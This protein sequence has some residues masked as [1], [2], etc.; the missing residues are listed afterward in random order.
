MRVRRFELR[1]LAAIL[2]GLW[3]ATCVLLLGWYR[4]GGP[5]DLAVGAAALVPAC[6]AATAVAWPPEPGSRRTFVAVAWLGLLTVLVL[7]PLTAAVATQA[8]GTRPQAIV[9]SPEVAY[10]WLLALAGTSLFAATGIVRRVPGSMAS[11][12]DRRRRLAAAGLLATVLTVTSAGA[13]GGAALANGA[14][15]RDRPATYSRFGPTGQGLVPPACD[16]GIRVGPTATL[17]AR[18]EGQADRET[19]GGATL[20]GARSGDDI[21]WTADVATAAETGPAGVVTVGSGGWRREPG[22]SWETVPASS[23]AAEH[24][25][26]TVLAAA[27]PAERRMAVEDR[28]LVYVE[29]ARARHCRIAIDGETFRAAFPQVRWFAGDR[30][31]HRWRGELDFYVFGDGQLGLVEAWVNG[32]AQ[33]VAPGAIQ[34]TIRVA[35]EAANRGE[36]VTVEPPP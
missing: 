2:A 17:S 19:L 8:V 12:A 7:L 13:I 29:E 18:L 20:E 16:G 31:L 10:A 30:S 28:G 3:T 1:L 32:E 26:A 36:P 22:T 33:P 34:A 25:D 35:L 14:A 11:M 9:P 6:I 27:L 21:S 24:L 23:L 15:L 5:L 4:P